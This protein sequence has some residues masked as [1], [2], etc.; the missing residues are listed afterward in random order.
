MTRDGER[1]GEVGWR[2]GWVDHCC[3]CPDKTHAIFHERVS[4]VGE[5][6]EEERRR[7][8]VEGGG[9]MKRTKKK[10]NRR[11]EMNTKEI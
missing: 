8:G 1:R 11:K 5:G 4:W 9:R 3:S 10:R 7:G 6:K 2:L